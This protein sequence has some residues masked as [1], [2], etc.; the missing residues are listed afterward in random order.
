MLGAVEHIANGHQKTLS[1]YDAAIKISSVYSVSH[2]VNEAVQR[3]D[4]M[5]VQCSNIKLVYI[6]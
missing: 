3:H 1:L 6:S 2:M 5:M 4:F